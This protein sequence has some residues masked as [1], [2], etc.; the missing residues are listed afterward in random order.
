MAYEAI[1]LQNIGHVTRLTLNRPS[2]LNC[3]TVQM[4]AEIR[5][6][7][8]GLE[9]SETRVLVITG[10]G[11]AFCAGQDLTE[12]VVPSGQIL[13]LGESIEKNYSPLVRLLRTHPIPVVAAVNGTAAGA[14]ANLALA[15]DIVVAAKSAKFLQPFCR[16]GLIPDTGGTYF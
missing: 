11:R 9:T 12:R 2:R 7:L 14:G 8:V 1:L 13:D 4:H 10:A 3:F 16:L 6:A 5:D 15:C